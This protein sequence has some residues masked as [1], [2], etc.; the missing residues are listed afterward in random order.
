MSAI[1]VSSEW[2]MVQNTF[3][4]FKIF[5]VVTS[6]PGS[7]EIVGYCYIT[8]KF[9]GARWSPVN[10]LL[11]CLYIF[12]EITSVAVFSYKLRYIVGFG[13]VEMAISTSPKPMIYR[14]LYEN[15]GHDMGP[16]FSFKTCKVVMWTD[17]CYN[18]CRSVIESAPVLT[19]FQN[20][21]TA[22]E[23]CF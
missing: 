21:T 10:H 19:N 6:F 23:I 13:L 8:Y 16:T 18:I 20:L 12:H 22:P 17:A 15:T 11:C 1:P 7:F 4:S 9:F 5:I 2:N 3:K 14:N